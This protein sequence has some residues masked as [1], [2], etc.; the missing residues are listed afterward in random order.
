[1]RAKTIWTITAAAA[2]L[3]TWAGVK[4]WSAP[5]RDLMIIVV[6]TLNGAGLAGLLYA[7]IVSVWDKAAGDR[8]TD[9]F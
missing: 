8:R 6:M 7:A 3:V 2:V 5:P 1:M 4:L 9:K